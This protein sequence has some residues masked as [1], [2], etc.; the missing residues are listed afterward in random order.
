M[1]LPASS[2][3]TLG[4]RGLGRSWL[5]HGS[6]LTFSSL[7]IECQRC[8]ARH[9]RLRLPGQWRRHSSGSTISSAAQVGHRLSE[10]G[11]EGASAMSFSDHAAYCRRGTSS[12]RSRSWSVQ[13]ASAAVSCTRRDCDQSL[14]GA[15]DREAQRA[16]EEHVAL[17]CPRPGDRAVARRDVHEHRRNWRCFEAT[18]VSH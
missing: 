13:Q 6:G 14:P 2:S 5:K 15:L 7:V 8:C 9:A 11:S 10:P 16:A 12:K 3:A 1:R 17:V 18:Q 4:G